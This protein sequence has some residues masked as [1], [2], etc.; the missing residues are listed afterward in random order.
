VTQDLMI[1]ALK[2]LKKRNRTTIS[3]LKKQQGMK[4]LPKSVYQ[5]RGRVQ[6]EGVENPV[7]FL[8]YSIPRGRRT[9]LG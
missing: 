4:S 8:S 1:A 5:E 9:S 2:D 7:S 6:K 3:K